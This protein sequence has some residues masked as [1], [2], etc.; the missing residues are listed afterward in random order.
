MNFY[1]RTRFSEKDHF[2]GSVATQMVRFIAIERTSN[3]V[4]WRSDMSGQVLTG[5]A[6]FW[7]N[8]ASLVSCGLPLLQ[9]LEVASEGMDDDFRKV[10]SDVRD[11]FSSGTSF[12]DALE[13]NENIFS[14]FEISMVRVGEA[15]GNLNAIAERLAAS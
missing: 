9:V 2:A 3:Q 8:F 5:R 11:S 6:N 4:E 10:I 1:S 14:A 7:R 15:A 12:S 13:Q